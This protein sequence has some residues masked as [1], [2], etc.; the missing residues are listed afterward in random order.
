TAMDSLAVARRIVAAASLAAKEYAVGVAPG[1]GRVTNPEGDAEARQFLDQARLDIGSLPRAVRA[2]AD[3][4]F[5]ALRAMLHRAA[6]P[7]A[8]AARAALLVQHIATVVGGALETFPSR[9]PSLVRGAAVYQEQGAQ[10][11]GPTG[12]GDGPKAKH[13]QGPP[14]ASLADRDAMSTVSPLDVYCKITLGVAGTAMPQFEETLSP[15]D[16]W[17]VATYVATLRADEGLVREGEGRYATTCA[18]CHGATGGGDGLLAATLS[19]RRRQLDS[20]VALRSDKMAFDAYLTFEQVETD[21]RVKNPA[22]ASDLEQ[23]FTLLRARAAA[24]AGPDEL[25]A[26]HARLLADLERAERLVA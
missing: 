6:P 12:H 14:P 16:R 5:V 8:V 13:L 1:R 25:A 18:S 26:I 4:D 9:P 7:A 24:G 15:E 3:S 20:G 21:V 19:V 10:W 11:H 23:A 17:A 2:T 22:L